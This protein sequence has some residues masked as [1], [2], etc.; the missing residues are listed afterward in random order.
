M[1]W[2]PKKSHFHLCERSHVHCLPSMC[3]CNKRWRKSVRDFFLDKTAE[4]MCVCP[5][6]QQVASPNRWISLDV[7]VVYHIAG[8][9]VIAPCPCAA[10]QTDIGRTSVRRRDKVK[11]DR[12]HC[13]MD[14]REKQAKIETWTLWRRLN[15][16]AINQLGSDWCC[17]QARSDTVLDRCST[18]FSL[19][20]D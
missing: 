9:A 14:K 5:L 19:S 1:N 3:S 7:V 12:F 6:G 2:S 20:R 16:S 11:Y 18:G 10:V 17:R 15:Y 8:A 4:P 13:Q